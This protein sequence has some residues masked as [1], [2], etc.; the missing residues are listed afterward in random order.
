MRA[1]SMTRELTLHRHMT[2]NAHLYHRYTLVYLKYTCTKSYHDNKVMC[3]AAVQEAR[4]N[5]GE[6]SIG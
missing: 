6:S 4:V 5:Q 2:K 3:I 1:G